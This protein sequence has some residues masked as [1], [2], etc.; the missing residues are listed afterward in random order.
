MGAK[1][2]T[3]ISISS[4]KKRSKS[5][6]YNHYKKK[7]KIYQNIIQES[8]LSVQKYKALDIIDV[9][10]LNICTQ[11]LEELFLETKKILILISNKKDKTD[12]D[13]II[14]RL[15]KINNDLS[16]NFRSYGTKD[17]EGL[18]KIVFGSDF[19]KNS[20]NT[21]NKDLFNIIKKYTHPISY[22]ILDWKKKNNQTKNEKI[23]MCI[24]KNRIVEDFMLVETAINLDCFDLSRTSKKFQKRVHGIKICFQNPEER[25]TLI[26]SAMTDD[27]LIN[28]M[29]LRD[30][31]LLVIEN[32]VMSL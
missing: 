3:K 2:N 12:N 16:M 11:N 20:L 28:C 7:I 10:G 24:T 13:D 27:M 26:I 5:Q 31:H 19:T 22:K 30:L 14:N 23:N 18:I 6:T 17:I 29:S 21:T 4:R 32:L 15:Q 25:K 8:I 1:K 9:A